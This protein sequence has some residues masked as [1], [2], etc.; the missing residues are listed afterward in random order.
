MGEENVHFGYG[1]GGG[2]D[3]VLNQNVTPG[4]HAAESA[5][6]VTLQQKILVIDVPVIFYL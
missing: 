6:I 1:G 4:S 5:A 2:G 3:M